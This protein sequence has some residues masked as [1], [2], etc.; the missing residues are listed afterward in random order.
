MDHLPQGITVFETL[1]KMNE[2]RRLRL[3]FLV[4]AENAQDA[5]RELAAALDSVTTKGLLDFL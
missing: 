2:A 1:R 3:V 4:E 5:R